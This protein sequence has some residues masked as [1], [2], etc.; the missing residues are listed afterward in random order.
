MHCLLSPCNFLAALTVSAA[1]KGDVAIVLEDYSGGMGCLFGG[2][3][4]C[5]GA[6]HSVLLFAFPG[7]LY[8]LTEF[9][10]LQAASATAYFLLA[11]LQLPLQDLALSVLDGSMAAFRFSM[12]PAIGLVAAGLVL[13]GHGSSQA[14]SLFAIPAAD[15]PIKHRKPP[16]AEKLWIRMDRDRSGTITREELMCDEFQEILKVLCHKPLE[17]TR[18]FRIVL[19]GESNA[20]YGRS[21]INVP[22]AVDFCMRKAAQN[23]SGEL[24]FEEF[25][26]FLRVSS[27]DLK[28]L[29]RAGASSR[30]ADLIFALFDLDQSGFLDKEEFLEVYRYFLGHRPTVDKFEEE[31]VPVS[32]CIVSFKL[33]I[34]HHKYDECYVPSSEAI[35]DEK[36]EGAAH[37]SGEA[38]LWL[39]YRAP[40]TGSGPFHAHRPLVAVSKASKALEPFHHCDA[41]APADVGASALLAL[42]RS[43]W[44]PLW[45]QPHLYNLVVTVQRIDAR[46][47]RWNCQDNSLLNKVLMPRQKHMFSRVQSETELR[48]F[49]ARHPRWDAQY[50]KLDMPEPVRFHW[51]S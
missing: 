23:A 16:R 50:E 14:K 43:Q 24:S 7:M 13:Y 26:S 1:W 37:A 36:V 22:Q 29:R 2:E 20:A 39:A 34:V 41:V 44:R 27:L 15:D 33:D 46:N 48:R 31:W 30:K 45:L 3:S 42:P 38:L 9:Q 32:G 12:L 51:V 8:T 35:L 40:H 28:V 17:A 47:E 18:P 6:W 4:S 11:A 21:E 19:W 5:A 49:Y 10:V 25:S